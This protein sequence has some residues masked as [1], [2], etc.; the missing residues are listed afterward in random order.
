MEPIHR[1]PRSQ[2]DMRKL[3]KIVAIVALLAVALSGTAFALQYFA[4]P[5]DAAEQD[6][7]AERTRTRY[8]NDGYALQQ[9]TFQQFYYL[10]EPQMPYVF[11]TY[12][13]T[14]Q[15][16]CQLKKDQD[17][18]LGDDYAEITVEVSV[19]EQGF[20]VSKVTTEEYSVW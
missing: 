19:M 10:V 18:C 3:T 11:G 15:R 20:Y 2:Y 13:Y 1:E 8:E 5:Q 4:D 12:E 6:A 7:R 14:Y 17:L 16:P 9:V